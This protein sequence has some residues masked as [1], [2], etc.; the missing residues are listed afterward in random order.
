[1][2]STP[3][4]TGMQ[5]MGQRYEPHAGSC[6]HLDVSICGNFSFSP[7][8]S[9][10]VQQAS[11]KNCSQD[12]SINHTPRELPHCTLAVLSKQRQRLGFEINTRCLNYILLCEDLCFITPEYDRFG[13]CP[14][15]FG[16]S[17]HFFWPISP[18]PPTFQVNFMKSE[19]TE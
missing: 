15:C 6:S 1:M 7:L 17:S 14:C 8:A 13:P 4:P 10:P 19:C 18:P 2:C 9:P 11:V 12:V 16:F 5:C 3:W